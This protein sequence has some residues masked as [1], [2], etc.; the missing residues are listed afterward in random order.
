MHQH[1]LDF[2]RKEFYFPKFLDRTNYAGW[3]RL[4]AKTIDVRLK[5]KVDSI[6]TTHKPVPVEPR[7]RQRM[8]EI[9]RQAE[10]SA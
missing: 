1:T 9:L 5:E 3:E 8:A 2:F 4:G 6:L 7:V 10:A